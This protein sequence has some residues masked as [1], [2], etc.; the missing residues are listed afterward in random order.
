MYPSTPDDSLISYFVSYTLK[1]SQ[2]PNN[3][4]YLTL[5]FHFNLSAFVVDLLNWLICKYKKVVCTRAYC[6]IRHLLP[7]LAEENLQL[8]SWRLNSLEKY[9]AR[10]RIPRNRRWRLLEKI[11]WGAEEYRTLL[12]VTIQIA[13]RL[14]NLI[15]REVVGLI[16]HKLIVYNDRTKASWRPQASVF[17]KRTRAYICRTLSMKRSNG[18][19]AMCTVGKVNNSRLASFP[20][21]RTQIE[22]L[23][24][25]SGI[26]LGAVARS[27]LEFGG[28]F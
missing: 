25:L 1:F 7:R 4:S 14:I 27:C 20:G 17:D 24:F 19:L 12:A 26:W 5:V 21:I 10:K 8:P 11:W 16:T 13:D 6:N 3:I 18:S 28:W 2:Y 9:P 23:V 15:V 22:T